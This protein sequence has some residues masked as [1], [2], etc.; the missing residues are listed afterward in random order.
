MLTITSALQRTL[1][2]RGSSI[3]THHN[4][5][6]RSW[7]ELVDR[8]SRL[9]SALKNCGAERGSRIACLALNSDRYYEYYLATSWAGCTFVPVNTRLAA[10]E[11]VYWQ[12]DSASQILLIDDHFL[13]MLPEI[14]SQLVSINTV[15]YM[16]DGE[17]PEG[18]SNYETLITDSSPVSPVDV[19]SEDIAGLFYT[20]GTTGR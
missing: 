14:R 2:V 1:Q 7:K 3:A 4:G 18:C 13:P 11:V 8:I 9:A 15:V 6:E 10:P 17:T 20:G 5:L 19:S 12:T 16:G